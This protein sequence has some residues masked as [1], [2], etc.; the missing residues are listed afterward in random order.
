MILGVYGF[1]IKLVHG[2]TLD[3]NQKEDLNLAYINDYENSS[4]FLTSFIA[5]MKLVNEGKINVN[6]KVKVKVDVKV[7]IKFKININEMV[8][9]KSIYLHKLK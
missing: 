6:I 1:P 5:Y 4:G 3:S 8:N 2:F 9:S 7:K